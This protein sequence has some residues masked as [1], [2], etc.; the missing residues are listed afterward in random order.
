MF[1]V[2]GDPEGMLTATIP[3]QW[4][5]HVLVTGRT[6]LK[7]AL[8][9]DEASRPG[10]YLLLGETEDGPLLYIG[11]SDD[12]GKRKKWPELEDAEKGTKA[13]QASVLDMDC[14]SDN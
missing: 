6:Q 4:T 5:G 13:R 9:R 12:I 8:K 7:D 10:V 11:E 3:F 14:L 2:D 1:F